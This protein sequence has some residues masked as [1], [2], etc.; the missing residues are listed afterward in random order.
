MNYNSFFKSNFTPG[1]NVF[2]GLQQGW[3]VTK[4][5]YLNTVLKYIFRVSVLYLSVFF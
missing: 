5:I 1:E 2:I 4:Y 3:T